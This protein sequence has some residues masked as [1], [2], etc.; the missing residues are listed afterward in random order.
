LIL[1][2]EP[3]WEEKSQQKEYDV[4]GFD[5]HPG[6]VVRWFVKVKILANGCF[7]G[8]DSLKVKTI[9]FIYER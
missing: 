8:I 2:F 9:L 5:S 6:L 3:G 4:T 1:G 7:Q